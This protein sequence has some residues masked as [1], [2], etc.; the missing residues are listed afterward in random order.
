VAYRL[1]EHWIW[2]SWLADAGDERHLF[3]LQAPRSLG[4]PDLRHRNATIGHAVSR[5]LV[6]WTTLPTALEAGPPG[7]WDGLATWTGSV[8]EAGGTWYLFY[9]GIAAGTLERVQQIG[10]ATSRD[11][12]HWE[13]LGDAP[14]IAPDPR[15]YVVNDGTGPVNQAWRDPWVFRDPAG[16]GYLA[17][18]TA[19]GLTGPRDGRGVIG[20]AV[21]ADLLHWEV[22]PPIEAPS[23]FGELEVPGVMRVG[24]DVLLSFSAGEASLSAARRAARPGTGTYVVRA[25]H[26]LGPFRIEASQSLA[27]VS[28]LYA[29][30]AVRGWDG[31]PVILG[32]VGL[33]DGRFV[34]EL[35]DPQPLEIGTIPKA[36]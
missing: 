3:H 16:D 21:S 13:R 11:L 18:I 5:D 17:L 24:D 26:E 29:G 34:G 20:H 14:V 28:P 23:G 22:R 25:R 7:A 35:A 4:D 10:V 6:S 33:V 27:P 15:W 9:T 8:I 2:D 32:F 30:H 1:A 12:V 36:S 19:T 31:T